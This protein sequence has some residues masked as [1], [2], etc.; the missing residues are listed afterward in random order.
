MSQK[1]IE[2]L[3]KANDNLRSAGL[4][5]PEFVLK[6]PEAGRSEIEGTRY[7]NLM[8]NDFLGI[9][10]HDRLQK[11]AISGVQRHGMGL[12]TPRVH[13]GT[14]SIHKDLEEKLAQLFVKETAITFPSS[15]DAGLGFFESIFN[16]QDFLFC[17]NMLHPS[18]V[19]GAYKTPAQKMFY[20]RLDMAGLEDQLKRSPQARFRVIVTE[21]VYAMDGQVAPLRAICDLAKQYDALVM[22][23]DEYGIGILGQQG[24]G[25]AESTETLKEIDILTGTFGSALGGLELGF[26]VT[27][28]SI[29][30]W[31]KQNS[32]PYLY[33]VAPPPMVAAAA[34]ES[35]KML[36]DMSEER[37]A[38]IEKAQDLRDR[39]SRVG[40][41]VLKSPHPLVGVITYD[42]V[43]TQK[44]IDLLLSENILALGLCYP[45]VP[46]GYARLCLHITAMH[47]ERDISLIVNTLSEGA[48]EL[49]FATRR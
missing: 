43:K 12:S 10:G 19:E 8:T 23:H 18:L 11:A 6:I 45:M 29:G 37:A 17:D 31:I 44:L 42:A 33:S 13:A 21:G 30:S 9:S 47:S 27:R 48:K 3:D 38:L 2:L 25:T 49:K 5:K 35:L 26:V 1:L 46:K 16:D 15:Y 34:L 20:T 22:L 14:L 32:K 7:I 41:T 28:A 39:L 4:Y 36:P 24:L 40:F